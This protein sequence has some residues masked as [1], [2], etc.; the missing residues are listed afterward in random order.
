MKKIIAI[1]AMF[2][3]AVYSLAISFPVLAQE[4]GPEPN[5]TISEACG[6]DIALLLDMTGSIESAGQTATV[7]NAAKGFVDALLPSTP[8]LIGLVQ[9]SN[10]TASQVNDLSGDASTIDSNIDGL[11]AAGTTNWQ[12]AL[13]LGTAM[14]EGGLDRDDTQHPDLILI[15][16]DGNPNVPT[17]ETV[18]LDAAITAAN[19]AKTSSATLPIR[20]MAIGIGDVNLSN[21]EDI[22]GTNVSDGTN[23]TINTDVITG[24][25]DN[26]DQFLSDLASTM[27]EQPQPPT[28]CCNQTNEVNM[29]FNWNEA[30]VQNE[31]SAQANTGGNYAGGSYG[32]SGGSGGDIRNRDDGEVRDSTT[33]S[34]GTGGNSAIGGTIY[35]G[36]ASSS[37]FVDNTVNSN[38]TEIQGCPCPSST[39]EGSVCSD[40]SSNPLHLNVVANHNDARVASR[41]LSQADTGNNAADGSYAGKG[42]SGGDIS[43]GGEDVD[44]AATGDG[45]DGGT[46]GPGGYV[47]TGRSVSRSGA[48]NVIN[49]N[50]TRLLR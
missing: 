29:I 9:F 39:D 31:V 5:P 45:G 7:K 19:A 1:T 10:G 24:N 44:T 4:V 50:V 30:E 14:L 8:T 17:D 42:G 34:G 46:G 16:T 21:L 47:S 6:L 35:T 48:V 27:C 33:G 15:I 18:A 32:G 22:S 36:D 38:L 41:V 11:S 25:F 40:C 20:I 23:I 12:Q 3:M 49:T 43:N 2:S 37:A 13:Q 26:L 28:N